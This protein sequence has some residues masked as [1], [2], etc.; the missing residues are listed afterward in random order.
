MKAIDG[1]VIDDPLYKQDEAGKFLDVAE[2]TLQAWRTVR[3]GGPKW[4]RVGRNI[5][6]R[7]S[8]LRA[9]IEANVQGGE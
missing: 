4:I 9:F 1:I 8:D 5:R 6:Y 7:E 3:G 2:A